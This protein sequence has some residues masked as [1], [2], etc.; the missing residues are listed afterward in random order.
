MCNKGFIWNPSNCEC[1]CDKSCDLGEYLG[2]KNCKCKNKL[3]DK[4]VEECIENIDRNEMGYNQ[5]LNVISLNAIPLDV[6]KKVRNS[7]AIHI[8]LFAGFFITSI[9]ISSVFIYFHWYFKK[10]NVLVKFNPGIQY[11][12]V[13][14][15]YQIH[16]NGKYQMS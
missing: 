9:C 12:Y 6:Y 10:D 8:V 13:L 14:N 2:S 11:L 15:I 4:L 3:V 16:I 5:T 7:C 1:K